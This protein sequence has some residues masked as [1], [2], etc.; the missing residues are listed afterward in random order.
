MT[1]WIVRAECLSKNVSHTTEHR[2]EAEGAEEA[3]DS[4]MKDREFVADLYGIQARHDSGAQT[5]QF[6]IV[7]HD[8]KFVRC[9]EP[10]QYAKRT[11]RLKIKR[12]LL[13]IAHQVRAHFGDET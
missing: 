10:V 1:T 12:G 13:P 2:R 11:V 9:A 7:A 8:T 5:V 4:A 6:E 3:I